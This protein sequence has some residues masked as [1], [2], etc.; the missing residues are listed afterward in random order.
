[1]KSEKKCSPCDINGDMQSCYRKRIN[2]G[3]G[4]NC[5]Q[6]GLRNEQMLKSAAVSR[7]FQTAIKCIQSGIQIVKE[8]EADERKGEIAA[9]LGKS[10][11][12]FRTIHKTR[13][14]IEHRRSKKR[15]DDF[16]YKRAAVRLRDVE[17]AAKEEP[18]F[19]QEGIHCGASSVAKSR[20]W[21]VRR[22]KA[23]SRDWEDVFR[24]IADGGPIATSR[25]C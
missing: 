9:T 25:P 6:R 1:R 19:T 7:L 12:Q 10:L 20:L 22:K 16:Q 3:T 5:G 23:S 4:E 15:L 24:L 2:R 13:D 8:N 17:I 14:V 11:A 18:E 21:P